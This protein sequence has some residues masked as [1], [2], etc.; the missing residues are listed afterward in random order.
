MRSQNLLDLLS[1]IFLF[2]DLAEMEQA[3]TTCWFLKTCSKF[4]LQDQYSRKTA[5]LK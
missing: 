3:A 2:G 1:A 5:E 4:I